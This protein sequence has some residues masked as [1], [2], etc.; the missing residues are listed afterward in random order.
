MKVADSPGLILVALDL[1]VMLFLLQVT[2]CPPYSSIA[3][4]SRV[5]GV[6]YSAGWAGC[7]H[8]F[9]SCLTLPLCIGNDGC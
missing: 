5:A 1:P 6:K 9:G 7:I 8:N 2:V 3:N 4:I